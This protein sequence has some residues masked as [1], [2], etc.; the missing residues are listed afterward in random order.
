MNVR[1]SIRVSAIQE[2]QAAF[3][4]RLKLEMEMQGSAL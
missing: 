2:L 4:D 3:E 1:T